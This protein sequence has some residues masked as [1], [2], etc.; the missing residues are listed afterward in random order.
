MTSLYVKTIIMSSII[1]RWLVPIRTASE[2][3]FHNT[4]DDSNEEMCQ[5][6][7]LESQKKAYLISRTV[8]SYSECIG[9]V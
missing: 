5:F 7:E 1:L 8:T 3:I 9:Y 2:Q 4:K 6:G